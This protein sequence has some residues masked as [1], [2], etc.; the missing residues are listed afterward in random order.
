MWALHRSFVR[1][2]CV[3][4]LYMWLQVLNLCSL[5]TFITRTVHFLTWYQSW[6]CF[7]GV[8]TD[9]VLNQWQERPTFQC[10]QKSLMPLTAR[11]V[12]LFHKDFA[13][14][15]FW[16]SCLTFFTNTPS[17]PLVAASTPKASL[18]FSPVMGIKGSRH[19]PT[20]RTVS[21]AI[22]RVVWTT[23]SGVSGDQ[24]AMSVSVLLAWVIRIS[25]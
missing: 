1:H 9:R 3:L 8:T 16:S 7:L 24:G 11:P 15:C 10:L 22:T 12:H 23:D 6:S 2:S 4:D 13:W 5:F 18:I 25:D 19:A 20:M 17:Q 14:S 21:R